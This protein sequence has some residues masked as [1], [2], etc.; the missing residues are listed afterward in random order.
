[1]A[2][3][4]PLLVGQIKGTPLDLITKRLYFIFP[5]TDKSIKYLNKPVLPEIQ[6]KILDFILQNHR[7]KGVYVY[8]NW[9]YTHFIFAFVCGLFGVGLK[10][11]MI[12][13]TLFEIW[14][15]WAGGYKYFNLKKKKEDL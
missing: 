2:D 13:H 1:M 4:S 12:F 14:E 11:Y 15:L 5:L 7:T 10:N 9:T 3:Q 6:L 8:N